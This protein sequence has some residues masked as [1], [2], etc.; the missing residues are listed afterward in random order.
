[1]HALHEEI[2]DLLLDERE[3]RFS[4]PLASRKKAMDFLARREYGQ[5]ELIKKLA[6]KGYDRNVAEKAVAK[7][8][9]EG[10]QSDQRFSGSFVQSRINQ[11]KG[12]VRIR[13]DLGQR[14][15]ADEVIDR[16]IEQSDADWRELA[17][18]VRH[19]KFGAA[20]PSDFK[21]K[22][23]QMQFLLYRGFE[24]DQVQAAFGGE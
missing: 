12:P 1:M 15:V 5:A 21:A 23:K 18:E 7:L 13:L 11:G 17:R 8:T 22:A 6:D 10:L 2:R 14:G 20:P 4:C 3:D 19:R 24:Q 16:A 9:A